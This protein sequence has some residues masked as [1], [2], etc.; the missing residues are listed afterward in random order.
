MP[1]IQYD[2]S[3]ALAA[4]RPLNLIALKTQMMANTMNRS[5]YP[6]A[7]LLSEQKRCSF[8]L[9][10]IHLNSPH[11]DVAAVQEL[12]GAW[13]LPRLEHRIYDDGLQGLYHE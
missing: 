9:F 6:V 12:T 10:P 13:G 3:V 5:I 4:I 7:M 1:S 11:E 8:S 2:I